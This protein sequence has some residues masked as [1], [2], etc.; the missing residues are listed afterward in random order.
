MHFCWG[1]QDKGQFSDFQNLPLPLPGGFFP[2]KMFFFQ[3]IDRL[4][5]EYFKL[6][7]VSMCYSVIM[8]AHGERSKT[9]GMGSFHGSQ[10]E[11][12]CT[13]S[14]LEAPLPA[15]MPP[16][17]EQKIN[18]AEKQ[19]ILETVKHPYS[20]NTK[21]LYLIIC[22]CVSGL[23]CSL[24]TSLFSPTSPSSLQST[25]ALLLSHRTLAFFLPQ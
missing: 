7:Q 22:T 20:Q 4:S 6:Q 19:L 10:E 14:C 1:Y 18:H 8:H 5:I 16:K 15:H 23:L 12:E 13:L 11:S 24:I 17:M 21:V 2:F 3:F 25:F 9:M